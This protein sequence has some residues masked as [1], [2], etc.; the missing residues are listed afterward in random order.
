[1]IEY[2]HKHL[3]DILI[4][5]KKGAIKKTDIV[6][7][8]KYPILNSSRDYFGFF[9]KYN[10]NDK[11]IIITS[12]GA[13]AGFVSYIEG[14]YWAG[15]LCFPYKSKNENLYNPKYIF[16]YLK[17]NEQLNMEKIVLTGS[18]PYINKTELE[19]LK[20]PIPPMDVQNEIVEV[21][22]KFSAL[23]AELEAELEARTKQYEY[24]QNKLINSK[25]NIAEIKIDD[26]LDYV[27]PTKYIVD[28]VEYSDEYITPVL[29]AGKSFILGYTNETDGIYPATKDN[30]VIIFD[31]F[32]TSMH[33][34]DFPFKVKSSALK[35]LV[36]KENANIRYL[37]YYMSNLDYKIG[38]GTHGRHWIS[39]YSQQII[40]IPNNQE[41][42]R[43]VSILDKF[44]A[45][46]SDI[47]EG[48]PAEIELRRKQYEYYRNKLLTF[49]KE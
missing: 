1:M 38:A 3:K 34:V 40:K 4:P 36:P 13:Y 19:L 47:K 20:I 35:I 8:G 31:D 24:Y 6:L 43:I 17:N 48:L 44:S 46:V 9:D 33:W 5:L 2:E 22:D 30:P 45:L 11:S 21:L 49:E 23:E 10:N 32:T 39:K 29:T 28:S 42:E 7:N 41:Q 15:S 37:Y 16:H 25:I 12:H 26:L 27:Q 18:I 14:K